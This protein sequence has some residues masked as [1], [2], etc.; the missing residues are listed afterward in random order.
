MLLVEVNQ[1]GWKWIEIYIQHEWK[2]RITL[3]IHLCF[4][5]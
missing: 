1:L 3:F 4:M 5:A 2:K